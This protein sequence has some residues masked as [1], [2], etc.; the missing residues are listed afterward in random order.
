MEQ[1]ISNIKSGSFFKTIKRW[2]MRYAGQLVFL[3]ILFVILTFASNKFLSPGNLINVMRQVS[4][5]AFVACG[6]TL[7][8]IA[9]GIDL[10][11]G[12]VMAI[13]G[14]VA[15]Y[16][17]MSGIP[18]FICALA[19][20]ATGAVAGLVNGIIIAKTNMQPFIVTYS[21]QIILRGMVYVI[22][23]AGT[24]RLTN[25]SFL[26]FGGSSLG[27]VP[28]PVIY[29]V[30]VVAV[31]VMI[32]NY[33]RLGRHIYAIGGNPKA[34]QFAGIN[35]T[36]IKIIIYTLSG[37]L[38]A[39]AGLVLTSRNSSMQPGLATGAEMD[40]IAAVVL[41]GTSMAGGQGA[42]AGT[43]IGAF[44]IGFINNGLNLSGMNSFWQYIVKGIV[45]LIAVYLDFIKNKKITKGISA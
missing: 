25:S 37:V 45:I 19:G 28:W 32:L 16:M 1:N 26:A 5:N 34:A 38:A 17:S 4:T 35:T 23:A 12:A 42:I 22:T 30:I 8:L 31:M 11:I 15:A 43:V 9:G 21:T 27:P 18:F 40:A 2:L 36:K 24:Y 41:G 33:T 13:T 14:M 10:S 3:A 6:M 39:I 20:I 7:I 44:I 29:M